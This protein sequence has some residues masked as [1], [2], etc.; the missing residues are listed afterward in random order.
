[1]PDVSTGIQIGQAHHGIHGNTSTR[2]FTGARPCKHL[3]N[4]VVNRYQIA[5]EKVSPVDSIADEARN[6]T[7][8]KDK[9]PANY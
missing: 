3:T 4:N 7:D 5:I 9:G 1:M 8:Q 2:H 6:V